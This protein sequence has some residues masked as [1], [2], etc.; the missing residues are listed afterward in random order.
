M[1]VKRVP[2][3]Y[4]RSRALITGCRKWLIVSF[5]GSFGPGIIPARNKFS[6]LYRRWGGRF[7]Q[8]MMIA[9]QD[10]VFPEALLK[11]GLNESNA[12]D[13]A[14]RSSPEEGSM[15]CSSLLVLISVKTDPSLISFNVPERRQYIPSISDAR[16]SGRETSLFFF[17]LSIY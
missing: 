8:A 10:D 17:F 7:R 11:Y 9:L 6:C 15:N 3:S 4:E 16:I 13:H 14:R 1:P 12:R 2:C 5:D